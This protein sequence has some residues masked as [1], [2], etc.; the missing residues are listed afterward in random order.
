MT[1]D[2]FLIRKHNTAPQEQ[3]HARLY[4]VSIVLTLV[5]YQ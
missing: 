5:W 4:A 3:K 2:V 1:V